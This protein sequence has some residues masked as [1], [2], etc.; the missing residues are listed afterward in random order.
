MFF[1]RKKQLGLLAEG[2]PGHSYKVDFDNIG[3]GASLCGSMHVRT[4]NVVNIVTTID[5]VNR[6]QYSINR[7]IGLVGAE[8]AIA[9]DGNRGRCSGR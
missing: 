2:Q 6:K 7:K 1:R 4:G 9:I 3:D 8:R 5:N